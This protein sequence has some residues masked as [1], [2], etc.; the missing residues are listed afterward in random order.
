M[1]V[2]RTTGSNARFGS[3]TVFI[4]CYS[5]PLFALFLSLLSGT[6][7]ASAGEVRVALVIGN[8]GYQNAPV[9]PN[10]VHDA[11]DVATALRR[12]GFDTVVAT[13]LTR[14]AMEDAA[15]AFARAARTADVA[16]FYYS[17]HAI[18]FAGTNYLLPIDSKL[19]DETDIRR[20]LRLDDVV[21]DLS[22]ARNLRILVLDACR[23]NPFADQLKRSI[24]ANRSIPIYRGLARINSPQGMIVSYATQAGS[25]AEDGRGKNSP[26]TAAFL[27]H[28]ES[29][30][31]IGTIF[32]KISADV[33]QATGHEQLPELSLSLIGEFYLKGRME[34]RV[35]PDSSFPPPDTIKDA[36]AAAERIDTVGAFDAFLAQYPDGYYAALARER[37][38]K[39][40]GASTAANANAGG[41]QTEKPSG[42]APRDR[43]R[44]WELVAMPTEGKAVMSL[45]L[46]AD[47]KTLVVGKQNYSI[48]LWNL[49]TATLSKTL[50]PHWRLELGV[51]AA[52]QDA[53]RIATL[54]TDHRLR[55]WDARTGTPTETSGLRGWVRSL[56]MSPDGNVTA[57]ADPTDGGVF[58][59]AIADR[60]LSGG[61]GTVA[62]L[63][64]GR[65]VL[66]VNDRCEL[67]TF[68]SG[69]GRLLQ[70][71]DL[72]CGGEAQPIAI[73]RDGNLLLF[74]Q[75]TEGKLW[76]RRSGRLTN[77]FF[78]GFDA[79]NTAAI[80]ADGSTIVTG[81]L[82]NAVRLWSMETGA[83][84][85]SFVGHKD[86][87]TGVALTGDGKR[88][89]SGSRDGS[90]KIWDAVNVSLLSSLFS[91]NENEPNPVSIVVRPDG[92][93]WTNA[94][95]LNY[96]RLARG[97]ESVPVPNDYKE[98]FLR[99][100]D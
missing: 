60:G 12:D 75:Q 17:G 85:R 58:G 62:V 14:S 72:R 30:E 78:S 59:P 80:S 20:M 15:I 48:N 35:T 88:I 77:V 29:P 49:T 3:K 23:D 94:Y 54:G 71:T 5:P 19:T 41:S 87:V 89:I 81:G 43:Y 53:S 1:L 52:S 86:I 66:S 68:D 84:I 95:G 26:Y 97:D 25:T 11:N 55:V 65:T 92:S 28:I 64:D 90:V 24:G 93:F 67:R 4:R 16:L 31:E 18:Q 73:S 44:G 34:I 99:Q 57:M 61:G 40:V 13:D 74:K 2:L 8:A 10:P 32:R 69:S 7:A 56:A 33:Y 51:M 36:F 50:G 96:L 6:G 42:Q 76:D 37:R 47:E 82:D 83:V 63:P 79:V 70:K 21:S 9:L 27:K 91:M 39:L 45:A 100:A 98:A 38:A 22:Q 46:S